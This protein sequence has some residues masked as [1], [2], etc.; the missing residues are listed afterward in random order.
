MKTERATQ[1]FIADT[2]GGDIGIPKKRGEASTKAAEAGKIVVHFD[3]DHALST[4]LRALAWDS[5]P[6][7]SRSEGWGGYLGRE[8]MMGAMVIT[9]VGMPG[10]DEMFGGR[11][12]LDFRTREDLPPEIAAFLGSLGGLGEDTDIIGLRPRPGSERVRGARLGGLAE[13]LMNVVGRGRRRSAA[14]EEGHRGDGA[15]AATEGERA[16]GSEDPRK[17]DAS[18]AKRHLRA[19][20]WAAFDNKALKA[21]ACILP[22]A[23]KFTPVEGDAATFVGPWVRIYH[24]D[25]AVTATA[26]GHSDLTAALMDAVGYEL[27]ELYGIDAFYTLVNTFG[28]GE[29]YFGFKGA[30]VGVVQR[31]GEFYTVV[32]VETGAVASPSEKPAGEHQEA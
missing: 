24:R 4:T 21:F 26:S 8:P 18:N 5:L 7:P 1:R 27:I 31:D 13:A 12:P 22:A 15:P 25:L 10:L 9:V 32:R 11:S 19:S 16:E 3:P 29:T 28:D 14:R 30:K 20:V 23:P 2:F 6:A 17:A